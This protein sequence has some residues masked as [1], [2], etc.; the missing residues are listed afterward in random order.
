MVQMTNPLDDPQLAF[1][2]LALKKAFDD[3]IAVDGVDLDVRRGEFL[4]VL[5]PSGCGKTTL[6]RLVAGFERPDSG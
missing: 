4:S 1:R 2:T 6:L 5:G 3:V